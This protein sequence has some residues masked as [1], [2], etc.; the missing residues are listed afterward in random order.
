MRLLLG[1]RDGP[2]APL[3]AH[4]IHCAAHD[5]EPEAAQTEGGG[6]SRHPFRV[7]E[8]RPVIANRHVKGVIF[9]IARRADPTP[10]AMAVLNGVCERLPDG[11]LDV[12]ERVIVETTTLLA[13]SVTARRTKDTRLRSLVMRVLRLIVAPPRRGGRSA[14]TVVA[15]RMAA[16]KRRKARKLTRRSRGDAKR[17]TC[18]D[19]TK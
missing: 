19:D 2:A 18:A 16:A 14:E 12:I 7:V 6:R 5:V 1:H 15:E 8:A 3:K 11:Q 4:V 13:Y 17:L 10:V 9:A